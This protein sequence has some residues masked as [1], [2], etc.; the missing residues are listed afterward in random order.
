MLFPRMIMLVH[1]ED[2]VVEE[3]CTA[4][5]YSKEPTSQ[6]EVISWTIRYNS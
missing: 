6:G 5:A 3:L 4:A 2:G 1:Y